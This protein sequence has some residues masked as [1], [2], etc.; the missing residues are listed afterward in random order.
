MSTI[1]AR[2]TRLILALLATILTA[3]TRAQTPDSGTSAAQA[4]RF[5]VTSEMAT[6]FAQIAPR[7]VRA[8][9]LGPGKTALVHGGAF[10]LPF[11][12]Q[13][14]IEIE[15]AGAVAVMTVTTDSLERASDANPAAERS[16]VPDALRAAMTT[17]AD[18]WFTFPLV[19]D[20]SIYTARTPAQQRVAA[21]IDSIWRPLVARRREVYIAVPLPRDAAANGYSLADYTRITWESMSA[22]YAQIAANGRSIRQRL[23]RARTIHVT[24]P[25]GTD[26]T[27]TP[28]NVEPLLDAGPVNTFLPGAPRRPTVVPGGALDL[29]VNEASA[30]GKIRA[31]WD[32]CNAPVKDEAI[33]ID[34]GR[35]ASVRTGTE[36]TCVRQAVSNLHL[37]FLSIGLNPTHSN[38]VR[39][40]EM[41]TDFRSAGLVLIGLG[42]N[43]RLGGSNAE[44]P[45]WVVPLPRATVEADGVAV[46]RDGVLMPEADQRR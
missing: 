33:D 19:E 18:V 12:Q 22:D 31:P 6:R 8:A 43:T 37:S 4:A 16:S 10:M 29:V 28:A 7:I 39:A 41:A 26:I 32:F 45:Q 40:S 44:Q 23:A 20:V 30:S 21:R 34:H 2:Q 25:E 9:D 15:R 14:A 3:A 42:S 11:M 24:S 17:S 38:A 46:L 36:E 13:L 5:V 1:R 27:F 35:V